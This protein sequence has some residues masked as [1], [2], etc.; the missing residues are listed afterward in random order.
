MTDNSQK[1]LTLRSVGAVFAGIMANFV[2]AIPVDLLLH[3]A[4]IFPAMSE[5]LTDSLCALAFS[6]R[7][8]A[9]I[10]GGYLAARF[11]PSSPMKHALILGLIGVLLSS[12]GA[13]AMWDQGPHWYP[14][15]LI[16]ISIPCSVT[17]GHGYVSRLSLRNEN[18]SA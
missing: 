17:G 6:Y 9:A 12:T 5:R 10:V 2:I 16:A 13:A 3:A 15:A 14:L 8:I 11:A 4:G 18:T 1:K 7:I